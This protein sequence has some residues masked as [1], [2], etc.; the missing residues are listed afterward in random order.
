MIDLPQQWSLSLE[1]HSSEAPLHVAVSTL[2][3]AAEAVRAIPTLVHPGRR[4]ADSSVDESSASKEVRKVSPCAEPQ[5]HD[6]S[7]KL[8]RLDPL[9]RPSLAV[10][11]DSAY[12]STAGASAKRFPQGLVAG[13]AVLIGRRSH[14]HEL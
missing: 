2:N 14:A 1:A 9:R 3:R 12:G 7:S 11:D 5:I 13:A 6:E 8:P 4:A 10:F